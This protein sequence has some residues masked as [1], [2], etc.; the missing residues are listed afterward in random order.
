[1]ENLKME[2]KTKVQEQLKEVFEQLEV[3]VVDVKVEK[4][5]ATSSDEPI[6]IQQWKGGSW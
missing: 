5:Y 1:M 4:G 6:S 2:D 3:K